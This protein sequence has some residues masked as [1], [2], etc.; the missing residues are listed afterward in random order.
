MSLQ[1]KS[2]IGESIYLGLSEEYLYSAKCIQDN[3][4]LYK[5]EN[6]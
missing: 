4:K 5:I 6:K 2:T 1:E 3:T